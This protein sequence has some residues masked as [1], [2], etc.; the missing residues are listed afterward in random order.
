VIKKNDIVSLSYTLKNSDGVEIDKAGAEDAMNYLHGAG[1]I[2][3]GL[4]EEIEKLKVGDKKNIIVSPEKGYGDVDPKL[5]LKVARSNFPADMDIKPG[6]QFSSEM[7]G[8]KNIFTVEGIDGDDINV[9]GNHPLAGQTLHFNIQV[10]AIRD[11]TEEELS[12]GHVHDGS[13]H[14]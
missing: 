3:P 6:M 8:K 5:M 13:H 10:I 4:E 11:A 1:N 9:N 12:H 2:V 14:H 7:S